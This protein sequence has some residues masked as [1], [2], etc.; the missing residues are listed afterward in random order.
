M[1]EVEELQFN[2]L[3]YF[4]CQNWTI[5]WTFKSGF[6]K[7]DALQQRRGSR[8]YKNET[9]NTHYSGKFFHFPRCASFG[10]VFIRPRKLSTLIQIFGSKIYS[11]ACTF[12][13]KKNLKRIREYPFD[14]IGVEMTA[15]TY[16]FIKGN[17]F[18]PTE[19]CGSAIV[20][21]IDTRRCRKYTASMWCA[22]LSSI[23]LQTM[24]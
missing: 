13:V 6:G 24:I 16:I 2:W 10:T 3:H 8:R 14:D 22:C 23:V 21:H 11:N 7:E 12:A 15:K 20:D 9:S 5:H 19:Q 18:T 4:I 17:I 1:S